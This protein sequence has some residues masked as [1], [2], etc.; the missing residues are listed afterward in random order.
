MENPTSEAVARWIFDR[1]KPKLALMRA[2]I[3]EETCTSACEYR[4]SA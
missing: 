3:I 4:P 2:V 1:L